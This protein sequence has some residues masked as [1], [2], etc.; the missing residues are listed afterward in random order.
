MHTKAGV[1][2]RWLSWGILTFREPKLLGLE[3]NDLEKI[4]VTLL[5]HLVPSSTFPNSPNTIQRNSTLFFE[6][7]LS[8]IV[9][10]AFFFGHAT[11]HVGFGICPQTRDRTC[12]PCSGSLESWPQEF[13]FQ[14]ESRTLPCVVELLCPLPTLGLSHVAHS[15]P[16]PLCLRWALSSPGPAKLVTHTVLGPHP[17]PFWFSRSQMESKLGTGEA[18]LVPL[19]GS[20]AWFLHPCYFAQMLFLVQRYLPP[21]TGE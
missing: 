8:S 16:G 2:A 12:A 5:C 20:A 10:F 4:L 9:W 11:H 19:S 21:E 6:W 15:T 18:F 14:P 13:D 1:I 17:Q 3:W 7:P